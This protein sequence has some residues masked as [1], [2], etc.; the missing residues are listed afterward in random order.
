MSF[1]GRKGG[2]GTSKTILNHS[3]ILNMFFLMTGEYKIG[4]KVLL[5]YLALTHKQT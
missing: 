5:P 3:A 2:K 4:M 1:P